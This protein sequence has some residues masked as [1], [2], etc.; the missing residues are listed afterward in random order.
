MEEKTIWQSKPSQLTNLGFYFFWGALLV[1][2]LALVLYYWDL[3]HKAWPILPFLGLSAV[4]ICAVIAV[5]RWMQTSSLH[6]TLTSERLLIETGLFSKRMQSLE[7]YRVKDYTLTEPFLYRMVKLGTVSILTS[8][9]S[10]PRVEMRAIIQPRSLLDTLRRQV[11]SR[12]DAKRVR[13]MDLDQIND[14]SPGH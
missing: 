1:L 14:L 3:L 9:P 10:T 8:D 4:L 12:R 6:Y 5:W 11:E 2:I 7:L 13:E